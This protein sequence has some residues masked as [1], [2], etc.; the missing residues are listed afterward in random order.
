[1]AGKPGRFSMVCGVSWVNPSQQPQQSLAPDDE[2]SAIS[3]SSVHVKRQPAALREIPVVVE[4][5]DLQPVELEITCTECVV[6]AM[7]LPL[8][9]PDHHG[10]DAGNRLYRGVDG[11]EVDRLAERKPVRMEQPQRAVRQDPVAEDVENRLLYV[12]RKV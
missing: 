6:A 12:T 3:L 8:E 7:S 4:T 10:I 1:M 2:L 5:C 11:A 9:S